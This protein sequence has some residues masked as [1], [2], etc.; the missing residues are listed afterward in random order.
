MF[1]LLPLRAPLLVI[2][3]AVLLAGCS[4]Q[5][6]DYVAVGTAPSASSDADT[7]RYTEYIHGVGLLASEVYL[8]TV[9]TSVLRQQI[10]EEPEV[11]PGPKGGSATITGDL[12]FGPGPEA[13]ASSTR[14]VQFQDYEFYD[15]LILNGGEVTVQSSLWGTAEAA[16]GTVQLVAQ[17]VV[18][19]GQGSGTH[20]FTVDLDLVNSDVVRTVLTTGGVSTELGIVLDVSNFSTS[21]PE[22]VFLTVIGMNPAQTAWF[23][24]ADADHTSMTEF[25]DSPGNFPRRTSTG[26]LEGS[27]KYSLSLSQLHQV[28]PQTWRVFVPKENLVSGR[29]FMSFG[30]KLQGLGIVCPYTS[31]SGQP[32]SQP[33]SATISVTAGQASARVSGVDA[34]QALAAGLP[35]S[36]SLNGQTF[37][38]TIVSVDSADQITLSASAAASGSTAITFT[39]DPT[40]LSQAKLALS[41]P[42]PTGPPDYLTTFDLME[43]SA[44]TDPTAPQPYY[45]LYANTTA[46]DFYSVGPGMSVSFSGHAPNGSQP[47]TPPSVKTVGFGPSAS[48][49]LSGVSQRQ[50]VIDRF[51]NQGSP[52]PLTPSAFQNF[53]TAQ[54]Q[55]DPQAG[56]DAHMTLGKPVDPSMGVIRVLGPPQVVALQPA[57]DLA[58]YLDSTIAQEWP[59]SVSREG[60]VIDFPN[61]SNPSFRFNSHPPLSSNTFNLICSLATGSNTGQGE[62]YQLPAPSTRVVWEC[63]D[64]TA[65][66]SSDPNNYANRG[67]DAHRRLASIISAAL[68]RG[69]FANQADWS[70]SSKFYSRSDLKY[71][72]F[73]KVMHD[74]ALDGTVYGFAYDDV[75]GQDS[76]LAGPLGLDSAGKVPPSDYGDVVKVELT[77][78]N[79]SAPDPAPEPGV[80]LQVQVEQ[81]C[82]DPLS[83]AGCV[84]HFTTPDGT[85]DIPALL[86][87]QGQA[88][89][90]GLKANTP[91]LAWVAPG[92]DN[93]SSWF[94]SYAALGQYDGTTGGVW[95]SS[96]GANTP[97]LVRLK[98]GRLQP[99]VG[100]CMNP[101]PNS[102]Q[103]A[104][105]PAPVEGSGQAVWGNLQP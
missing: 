50:A 92:G 31:P 53:V 25:D 29:I 90:S 26:A 101:Q 9:S 59:T 27:E 105:P 93:A 74:F 89:V 2:L 18:F 10:Q 4:S 82:G 78:P 14:R 80:P 20:S 76:T 11:I 6:P 97:G 45:T 41:T 37:Q 8:D 49:I 68:T 61:A 12:A 3:V 55:A 21:P 87:A 69:V 67:T 91:Y 58:T 88:T 46:I 83:L 54:A 103:G 99:G 51:N 66:P 81:A 95:S 63:D 70:D 57:G 39:P 65:N 86:N 75:Y 22:Q 79:F 71:N 35:Y 56:V 19:S 7:A 28:G 104:V 32:V 38:G 16:Q 60:V 100:S 84:V 5:D 1:K 52:S 73:S 34:N 40:V 24:L 30:R 42:S 72:F 96:S 23:Y 98:M 17:D 13:P 43:L 36:Y 94:F 62:T 47:G 102:S 48:A 64:P 77:I 85:Q 33:V 15:G 44:T